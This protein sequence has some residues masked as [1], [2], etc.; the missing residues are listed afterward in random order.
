MNEPKLIPR[1]AIGFILTFLG[2]TVT[3]AGGLGTYIFT[4]VVAKVDR[5]EE[6][7][8]RMSQQMA[9]MQIQIDTQAKFCRFPASKQGD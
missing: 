9:V 1:W 7:V 8:S 5:T 6:V 3:V 2:F 4:S